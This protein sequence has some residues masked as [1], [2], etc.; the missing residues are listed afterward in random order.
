MKTYKNFQGFSD[1]CKTD[2][3]DD[4]LKLYMNDV[5]I[6]AIEK[7]IEKNSLTLSVYYDNKRIDY[8]F[9]SDFSMEIYLYKDKNKSAYSY[10]TI[11]VGTRSLVDWY[12]LLFKNNFITFV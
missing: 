11:K 12:T 7:D 6:E 5:E 10:P 3:I 2:E 1:F 8:I 4:F 9:Y